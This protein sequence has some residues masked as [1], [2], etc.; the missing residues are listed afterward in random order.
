[1]AANS[2]EGV[3]ARIPGLGGYLAKRQM[4]EQ[5][6]ARDLAQQTTLAR[7]AETIRNRQGD[8]AHRAAVLKQGTEDRAA[9]RQVAIQAANDRRDNARA[10]IDL[11]YDQL[12]QQARTAEE[13]AALEKR[14]LD[15]KAENDRRRDVT[16]RLLGEMRTQASATKPPPGYRP[17]AEGNLE[18]IPGGPADTKLQGVMNQDTATLNTSIANFDRLATAANEV[19]N[20]PGLGGIT[21][22]RGAIPNIPGSAA[23]NAQA[24]LDTLKAQVGFGVLQELRNAS[25]TGG[26]LGQVTEKEHVLL[27]NALAALANAQDTRQMQESLQKIIDYTA[28]AKERLRG[29]YNMKHGERGGAPAPAPEAPTAPPSAPAAPSGL[30][31]GQKGTSKSGRPMTVRGGKWTYD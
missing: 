7:L 23:A 10:L 5:E 14:R 17:T 25:K 20:H 8:E 24:K 26:A 11:R 28:E 22:L 16:L 29:A 31:E 30:R 6:D 27:Q 19:K 18:A 3:L 4:N 15:D 12:A 2:Y 1:M 9:Q 13:K 21:G